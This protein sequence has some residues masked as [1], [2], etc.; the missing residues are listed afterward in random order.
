MQAVTLDWVGGRHDFALD[1][2]GLRAVQAATDTGPNLVLQRLRF[3]QWRVDD[4]ISVLEQGLIR[5]G[6]DKAKVLPLVTTTAE[7]HGLQQL[8]GT[9][10]LVLATALIGPTDD[11]VG[12]P[13][14]EPPGAKTPAPME[15]GVSAG[16]T[17]PG[18]S[19]DT[20]PAMLMG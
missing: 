1:L 12:D 3:G 19:P 11:K 15:N 8:V 20:D 4:V 14:G 10:Y 17:G 9:A 5:A 7:R 2:G 16:S 13:E 6:M 18:P